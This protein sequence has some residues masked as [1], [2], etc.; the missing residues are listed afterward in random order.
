MRCLRL[1]GF[2]LLAAV[3]GQL[4]AEPDQPPVILISIDT[5]RADRL[6]CYGNRKISTPNIDALAKSGTLF[7]E[8]S[9]QVPLTLPSH[10]GLMTSTHPFANGIRDNGEQLGK[11]ALTLAELLK[12]KGYRTAA[13]VG[14]F[15]LDR[16]FGLDQG[17]DLYD[18]PFDLDR[19]RGS[20]PGDIKR[21]A[22]MVLG[23]ASQ[24]IEKNSAAPFF[25]FVHLYDMHSPYNA[26]HR[27]RYGT[28]GYEAELLY[29][30]EQLG[31]FFNRLPRTVFDAAVIVLTSDHG[32]GLGDHGESTHGY[33]IYQSTLH[34]P[35]IVRRQRGASAAPARRDDPASLIDVAPTLLDLCGLPIPTAMQGRSLRDTASR[36]NQIYSESHYASQHF[37]CVVLRCLRVG[38]YKYIEA[39]KPE[40]YDLAQ[41]PGEAQNIYA[42]DRLRA[43]ALVERMKRVVSQHSVPTQAANKA[44]TSEAEAKLRSL[45]YLAGGGSAVRG[46]GADPKDRIADFEQYGR[47]LILAGSG[48]VI[49]ANGILE[50]LHAKYPEVTDL[51]MSMALNLQRLGRHNQAANGLR[52]VARNDPR[53]ARAHY[54][55]AVS[56]NQLGQIDE[57]VR[58]LEAALAIAPHYTQASEL[59]GLIWLQKKDPMRARQYFQ[60]VL[61]T[62]PQN[63]AARYNLGAL[64]TVQGNWGEAEANLAAALAARPDSPEA[65]NALGSLHLRQGELEKAAAAF[66]RT[67]QLKPDFAA[68]HYNLGLVLRKQNRPDEAAKEFRLALEADPGFQPARKALAPAQ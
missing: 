5:L 32:E 36:P 12:A 26:L 63:F 61:A 14:G 43:S 21:P 41:D 64:E 65:L 46:P 11:Q 67:V 45:G 4:R 33:F 17:F 54:N 34:V 56:L 38:R 10:V 68:A 48:S 25:A 13:F 52:E 47:A 24:W 58:E 6:S 23:T 51:S 57:A 37:G 62:D 50:R 20:D 15:V 40:L 28:S 53:S 1:I 66:R 2:W 49:E 59:S 29:V 9:A 30:D 44:L 27:R 31:K 55:L 7:T 16:R 39:P 3:G 60:Q 22:E 42:R 8:A 35:L 19:H 18:S